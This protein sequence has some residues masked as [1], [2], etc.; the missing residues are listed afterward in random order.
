MHDFKELFESFSALKVGVIGD[1]MLDTY[2]WGSVDRI[3]PEGPVPIVAVTKKEWRIGGAGNVALNVS[4]LGAEVTIL[5]VIGKDEEGE[6]LK[7]LLHDNKIDSRFIIVS[8]KRMTAN[9]I[10]II[11]RNQQM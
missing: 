9:K 10:R 11:G 8:E 1:V 4:A 3:S 5:T 6:Q 2:W 7:K